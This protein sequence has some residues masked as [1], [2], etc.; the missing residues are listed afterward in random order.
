[1]CKSSSRPLAPWQ[2]TKALLPCGFSCSSTFSYHHSHSSIFS[3]TI[4]CD[5]S[6]PLR[7]IPAHSPRFFLHTRVLLSHTHP[8]PDMTYAHHCVSCRSLQLSLWCQCTPHAEHHRLYGLWEMHAC[9]SQP[10][11]K[12]IVDIR[13]PCT[14]SS[15][16][17]PTTLFVTTSSTSSGSASRASLI[18]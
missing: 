5:T 9:S 4:T 1:M 7:L 11:T 10:N 14:P 17:N 16:S 12:L 3:H 2:W 6:Q 8:Y 13:Q 18:L 15:H